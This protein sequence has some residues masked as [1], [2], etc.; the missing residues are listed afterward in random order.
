MNGF[1]FDMDGVIIDSQPLHFDVEVALCKKYGIELE[2]GELESYVGMRS[3]D[4]WAQIKE[5][6]GASF[7][8]RAIY[9]ESNSAK[10]TYLK[11]SNLGPIAGINDLLQQLKAN[12][13]RIGLASSS[14]RVFIESV[15]S[16]FQIDSYFDIVVSGEEVDYGKPAPDIYL[17]AAN[18]LGVSPVSCTVLEDA[19]QG[20]QSAKSANM[21]VIG[22]RN[23]HS[24]NQDL[25]KADF[26]VDSINQIIPNQHGIQI[27]K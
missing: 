6:H 11:E 25:S 26:Q 5:R 20:I 4:V 17:A 2:T 8:V 12:Q 21:T 13:Y 18:E 7:D 24:G 19:A 1:I 22:Y 23:L 14:P 27:K 9:E 16:T 3:E 15:L 10:L